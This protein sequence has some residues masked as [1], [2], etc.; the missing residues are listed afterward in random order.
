MT[1]AINFAN[2]TNLGFQW[3]SGLSAIY[4]LN[5]TTLLIRAPS[6]GGVCGGLP[7]TGGVDRNGQNQSPI[8]TIIRGDARYVLATDYEARI[9]LGG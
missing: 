4:S 6:G 8:L 9:R 2:Q 5:A 3:L 1:G 7:L